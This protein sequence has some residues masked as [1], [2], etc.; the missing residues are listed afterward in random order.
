MYQTKQYENSDPPAHRSQFKISWC[1]TA[2]DCVSADRKLISDAH[3][4]WI[5]ERTVWIIP[6]HIAYQMILFGW[7]SSI[8]SPEG[9][10]RDVR[11]AFGDFQMFTY[12]WTLYKMPVVK[13]EALHK[14]HW[15]PLYWKPSESE[16]S[17]SLE[18]PSGF[19]KRFRSSQNF[20]LKFEV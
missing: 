12:K 2:S 17:I 1:Q 13:E 20:K 10:S 3:S 4:I 16:K 19:S 8:C 9:L 14:F 15:M 11:T 5:H 7:Y 6:I 18:S